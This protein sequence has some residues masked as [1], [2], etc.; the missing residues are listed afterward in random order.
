MTRIL[1][2]GAALLL[3][4]GCSAARIERDCEVAAPV[5]DIASIFVPGAGL[6]AR[7]VDQACDDPAKTARALKEAEELA[8][9]LRDQR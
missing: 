5:A 4:A 8:E 9:R 1:T 7:V 3:L 6:A 2:I